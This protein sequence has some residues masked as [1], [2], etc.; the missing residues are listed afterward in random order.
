MKLVII[1]TGYN[2]TLECRR[3]VFVDS[4]LPYFVGLT[5]LSS[6]G[7]FVGPL[8]S[9]ESQPADSRKARGKQIG[10]SRVSWDDKIILPK[11]ASLGE[12][13]STNH[14]M[15]NNQKAMTRVGFE[16]TPPKRPDP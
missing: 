11:H 3:G 4:E 15:K 2:G 7:V 10:T 1:I 8:T 9:K 14:P 6:N 12:K 16:P 5:K 13:K